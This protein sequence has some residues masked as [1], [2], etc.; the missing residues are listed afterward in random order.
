M[1]MLKYFHGVPGRWLICLLLFT[2]AMLLLPL[3]RAAQAEPSIRLINHQDYPIHLP[4]MIR[5]MSSPAASLSDGEPV[6]WEGSNAVFIADIAAKAQKELFI[7]PTSVK[8]P[9]RFSITA[10][11]NG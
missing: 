3:C 10:A 5:G 1:C 8:S 4:F 2:G 11:T 7:R 6:Q 9:G